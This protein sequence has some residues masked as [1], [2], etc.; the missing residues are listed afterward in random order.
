MQQI[1][2]TPA[3][4]GYKKIRTPLYISAQ[5]FGGR[6]DQPLPPQFPHHSLHILQIDL[7]YRIHTVFRQQK[8]FPAFKDPLFPLGV[9]SGCHDLYRIQP[10]RA[11]SRSNAAVSARSFPI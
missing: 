7:L 4:D 1:P 10:C 8:P 2:F 6:T 9:K 3:A 5:A 11:I